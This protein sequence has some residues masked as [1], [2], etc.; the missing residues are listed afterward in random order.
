MYLHVLDLISRYAVGYSSRRFNLNETI[1][2]SHESTRFLKIFTPTNVLRIIIVLLIPEGIPSDRNA[3]RNRES[4][5]PGRRD[6]N[7]TPGNYS[8]IFEL[9][10][11]VCRS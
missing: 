9:G 7:D 11:R 8:R 6:V 4:T 10:D 1:I 3:Y 2:F 5:G